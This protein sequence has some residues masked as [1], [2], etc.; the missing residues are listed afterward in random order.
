MAF[1]KQNVYNEVLEKSKKGNPKATMILQALRR[2][3]K[4]NVVDSLLDDLLK[5]QAQVAEETTT[6]ADND[7]L[8]FVAESGFV[9]PSQRVYKNSVPEKA[10]VEEEVDDETDEDFPQDS[11]LEEVNE[12]ENE[13]ATPTEEPK[14]PIKEEVVETKTE[15]EKELDPLEILKNKLDIH[16]D[17]DKIIIAEKGKLDDEEAVKIE[18]NV[19]DEEFDCLAKV[20]HNNGET[21]KEEEKTQ[22]TMNFS[23]LLDKETDGLFDENEIP[24]MDFSQYLENKHRDGVR[25]RRNADYFKAFSPEDR[26]Q[27]VDTKKKTYTDKFGDSLHDIDRTH[28]DYVKSLENLYD[29]INNGMEEDE[30]EL[31][32]EMSSGA[33]DEITSNKATMRVLNRYWDSNDMGEVSSFLNGLIQKYGKQ[34]VLS[35]MGLLKQDVDSYSEFRK[36]QIQDEIDRYGNTIEKTLG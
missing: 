21:S 27:Y 17:K 28:S 9:P 11:N 8:T 4:Q 32:P 10:K 35:A 19:T 16:G 29:D 20:F 5:P 25:A 2:G 26:H 30:K 36:K 24:Q 22:P 15:E 1:L 12:E 3:E 23:E 31:S 34:N 18:I 7:P 14:E 33:Y 13:F 6:M